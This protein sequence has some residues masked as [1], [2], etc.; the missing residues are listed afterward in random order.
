M[1]SSPSFLY[2]VDVSGR[3][4]RLSTGGTEWKELP[5]MGVDFKRVSAHAGFVWA[6][7]GDHQVYLFVAHRDGF[8]R[9]KEES[10]ENQVCVCS[11]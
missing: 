5:Y 4:Y 11:S 2:G 9:V 7:G 6:L 8:I 1:A 3:C 10:Y